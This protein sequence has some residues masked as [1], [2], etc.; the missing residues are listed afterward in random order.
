MHAV[1]IKPLDQTV[2]N[3]LEAA[4]YRIPRFQRPYPWDRANLEDFWNDA[5]VSDDPDYF[6]GSFVLYRD[7]SD[8]DLFYVVDGQ[9]RLTTITILLAA[10][11]DALTDLGEDD[12]AAGMQKVI[13]REDINNELT[14]V[15]DS[16][17]PYPFLQECIQTHTPKAPP[18]DL[19]GEQEALSLRIAGARALEARRGPVGRPGWGQIGRGGEPGRVGSPGEPPELPGC[20]RDGSGV[21]VDESEMNEG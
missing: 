16:E 14:F 15:L 10:I 12:L 19:S 18:D 2:K 20:G 1:D 3:L 7:K 5:V 11:R 8:A 9:Q 17:T 13:E 6:I 21:R 4:F